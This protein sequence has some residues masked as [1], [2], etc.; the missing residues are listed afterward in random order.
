MSTSLT[1]HTTSS[2]LERLRTSTDTAIYRITNRVTA[3]YRAIVSG[4]EGMTTIEYAL[5]TLAAAA[6]A[7]ILLLVVKSGGIQSAINN[8]FTQALT[9]TP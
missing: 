9:S 4:E 7:G 5:G 8:L 2:A 6:L 1:P 3:R